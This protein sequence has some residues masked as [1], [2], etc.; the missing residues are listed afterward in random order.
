[1]LNRVL[2]AS[3]KAAGKDLRSLDGP[4]GRRAPLLSV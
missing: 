1:M 2:V 4:L 3:Y